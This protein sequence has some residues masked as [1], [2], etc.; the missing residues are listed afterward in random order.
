MFFN[1][2][3]SKQLNEDIQKFD[4]KEKLDTEEN[5]SWYNKHR[6]TVKRHASALHTTLE[7]IRNKVM[8][9]YRLLN[10]KLEALDFDVEQAAENEL[11]DMRSP[12]NGL[13]SPT[14]EEPNEIIE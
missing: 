3:Q 5:G 7:R 8:E 1:N 14:S 13:L 9:G 6:D 4:A 2:I 11:A 10:S 12:S